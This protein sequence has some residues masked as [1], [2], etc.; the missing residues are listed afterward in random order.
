MTFKQE[1]SLAVP[2]QNTVAVVVDTAVL[3]AAMI[4]SLLWLWIRQNFPRDAREHTLVRATT[5]VVLLRILAVLLLRLIIAALVDQAGRRLF[6][7]F[8]LQ[9]RRKTNPSISR[10]YLPQ[11]LRCNDND[12]INYVVKTVNKNNKL[13][14]SVVV[15]FEC[16]PVQHCTIV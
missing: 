10:L 4:S 11:L 14:K 2:K 12:N 9:K 3:L 5:I 7:F 6:P 8:P 13:R 16:N 15:G 1:R